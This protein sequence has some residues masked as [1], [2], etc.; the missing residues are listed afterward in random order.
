[1]WPWWGNVNRLCWYRTRPIRVGLKRS[2]FFR[3]VVACISCL[4]HSMRALPCS[5]A[6][7]RP[8]MSMFRSPN[9]SWFVTSWNQK[10]KQFVK[11]SLHI[12]LRFPDKKRLAFRNLVQVPKVWLV[13]NLRVFSFTSLSSVHSSYCLISVLGV[14]NSAK[15]PT[16]MSRCAFAHPY[17]AW[18]IPAHL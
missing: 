12:G 4:A 18:D 2:G 6:I 13:L 14:D 8:P 15:L 11:Y 10:V 5:R 7:A 16:I 9:I 17:W 1:M 3:A